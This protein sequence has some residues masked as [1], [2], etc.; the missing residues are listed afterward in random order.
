MI[1]KRRVK[2]TKAMPLRDDD[3]KL[4]NTPDQNQLIIKK[5]VLDE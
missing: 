2:K 1:A 3:N 5:E 4:E